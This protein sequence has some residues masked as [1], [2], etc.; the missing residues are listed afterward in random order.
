MSIATFSQVN[1]Y[2]THSQYADWCVAPC[3]LLPQPNDLLEVSNWDVQLARLQQFTTPVVTM[4]EINGEE[5]FVV[6]V[7]P[8]GMKYLQQIER[9]LDDHVALDTDDWVS[10]VRTAP[11]DYWKGRTARIVRRP[12]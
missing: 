4:L 3:T 11:P 8:E 6:L 1:H 7:P 9:D 12:D 5:Q 2:A 10:R